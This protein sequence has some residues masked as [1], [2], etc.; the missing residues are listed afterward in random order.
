MSES[1]ALSTTYRESPL[2]FEGLI[3]DWGG[4]L[5]NDIR[6][7]VHRWAASDGIDLLAYRDIM[8]AWLGADV[9]LE[10]VV[11]PVHALER[12]EIEV[13]HFE[14]RLAAELGQ[15]SHVE[16]SPEGLLYRM[17]DHFEHAHDMNALVRRVHQ[18]GIR[19]ALLSNSWGN[20]YPRDLWHDMFDVLVISGEVGMRKPEERIFHYTFDLM[21]MDPTK[22]VFVDDLEH[23][24]RAGANLGMTGVL[25]TSY[26][27][28]LA[29]LQILFGADLT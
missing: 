13:P 24:I 25:H 18:R 3:V 8:G 15:R 27:Q 29:E 9:A 6:E 26:E 14:E 16:I 21:G 4:V 19:T 17:F 10:A 11:N 1:A 22:C 12:G 5:T 2:G 23:N 7:A 20:P 28:T